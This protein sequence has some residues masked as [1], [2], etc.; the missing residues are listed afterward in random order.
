MS[1][2]INKRILVTGGA[3][4]LGSVLIEKLLHMG[5]NRDDILIPRSKEC[6]LRIWENCVHAVKDTD[7]VIHL[8]AKVGGI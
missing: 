2:L 7:I 8:A 1:Y 3:G 4:F 6:D 5:V